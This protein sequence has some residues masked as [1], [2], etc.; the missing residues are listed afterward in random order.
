MQIHRTPW[1]LIVAAVV[2]LVLVMAGAGTAMAL[3]A[4]HNK[5]GDN[6]ASS[7]TT[8][9][10]G[11]GLASPSPGVTPSPIASPV[12]TSATSESNDGVTVT[13]PVGWTVQAK[14]TESMVLVD[15]DSEGA[16]TLASGTSSPA[17]TALDN[18]GQIDSYFKSNYPDARPC[19]NTT[20]SNTT[21]HGVTGI[22][23]VLCFTVT[24]GS[25][26][27]AGA[28]SLFVGANS[29]GSVYYLVMVVTRESNLAS[30][31]GICKPVLDSVQWK[32][33]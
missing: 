20:T 16:V 22:S 13:V 33:S 17:A 10:I 12:S 23:W 27:V 30:Y 11:A 31:V 6:N 7:N 1:T 4:N 26:S 24:S 21:F 5:N 19:A 3:L 14:D 29:G 28:A 15:P 25:Q 8:T 2:A 32:L 18:K 9:G